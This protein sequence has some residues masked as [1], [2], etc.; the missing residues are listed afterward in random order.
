M[1]G[2]RHMSQRYAPFRGHTKTGEGG[3]NKRSGMVS[4]QG[5]DVGGL[6]GRLP[7]HDQLMD[8]SDKRGVIHLRYQWHVPRIYSIK[9]QMYQ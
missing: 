6:G 4:R 8:V 2:Q 9:P 7:S 5:G 1:T 3:E